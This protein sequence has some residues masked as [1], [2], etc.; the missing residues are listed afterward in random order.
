L[1]I[2]AAAALEACTSV[3][4]RSDLT[5]AARAAALKVRSRAL[6]KA[7]RLDEAIAGFEE[8]LRLAPDDAELHK[9]RG[10]IAL[11]AHDLDL[12]TEHAQQALKIDPKYADAFDLVGAIYD[13]NGK[14]I[15]AKAAYNQAILLD[16]SKP[17]PRYHLYQ[18]FMNR[19]PQEAL[20]AIDGLL[21][22]PA[23]VTTKPSPA[24]YFARQTTYRIAGSLI[25][26]SLLAVLGQVNEAAQAYD[27]AVETDPDALTYT[28]RAEF[29]LKSSA[30][31]KVVQDDL[32]KALAL[33][34]DFWYARYEQALVHFYGARYEAAAADFARALK[35]RPVNGMVHW[36]YAR[37][38]RQLGRADEA[39]K[40]AITALEVDPRFA[41]GKVSMLQKR[42]YLPALAPGADPRPALED[43]AR[44]CML[45]Q[46]CS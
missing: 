46:E 33:D 38:L 19:S 35:Q 27:Q 25:R 23:S 5:D 26:A 11:L 42:G 17:Q 16:P 10:W 6:R 13:N 22:L 34:P 39:A 12:A 1:E 45:D 43:A 15:E 36:W 3:L 20:R 37:T 32:D 40:E 18:L 41:F 30:A 28:C 31:E 8:A 4:N 29:L 24:K 7:D 2:D 9:W 21:L 44:A 14:F